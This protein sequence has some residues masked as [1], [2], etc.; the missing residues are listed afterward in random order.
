MLPANIIEKIQIRKMLLWASFPLVAVPLTEFLAVSPIGTDAF[1]F[2]QFFIFIPAI[3]C[4][5]AL[6][7]APFF[8][9]IRSK[10]RSAAKILLGSLVFVVSSFVGLKVGHFIRMNAFHRLAVRS[11]PLIDAI[12][13]YTDKYGGPPNSLEE[14]VPEFLTEVPTTG[15]KAYP[16]FLYFSGEEA[17]KYESNRWALTVFTPSGGFNFDQFIYFPN[18]NYPETGYGGWLQKIHDW[19]YVHE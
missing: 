12:E 18:Q 9:L 13:G 17:A 14:L 1:L 16:R 8:L 7:I 3:G 2:F 19:A 6:V 11:V 4:L 5:F 10:Q 15:I